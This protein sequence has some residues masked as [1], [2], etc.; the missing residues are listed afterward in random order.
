ME[1]ARKALTYILKI[2][3]GSVLIVI[4]IVGG[5]YFYAISPFPYV[6]ICMT[7]GKNPWTEPDCRDMGGIFRIIEEQF[8][9]GT[10]TRDEVKSVLGEYYVETP[11]N[12]FTG[13]STDLYKVKPPSIF[14]WDGYA[15]FVYDE[16][17]ILIEIHFY[18]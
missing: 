3:A 7:L 18:D 8:P 2:V 12:L 4:I 9:I 15:Q 13:D 10:T 6:K 16:N 1:N 5:Y 11:T 17:D 14:S